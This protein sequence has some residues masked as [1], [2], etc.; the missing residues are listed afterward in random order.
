MPVKIEPVAKVFTIEQANA[1]LPLVRAITT[2]L[3]TLARDV[4]ERRSRLAAFK[5][6]KDQ[7]AGDPYS[8]ELA[9]MQQAVA[10]DAQR[11]Q[12]YIDELRSLGL[13]PK[14]AVEGLVDFPSQ[15]DGRV[16]YLCWKLGEAEVTHWHEVEAGF[17]GR[18]SLVAGAVAHAE[19]DFESFSEPADTHSDNSHPEQAD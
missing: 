12:E 5:S 7:K 16:V 9:S 4:V 11:L 19:D 14:G 3:T 13:E 15:L 10:A 17:A 18:Q 8:D 6:R 2:D 1:M